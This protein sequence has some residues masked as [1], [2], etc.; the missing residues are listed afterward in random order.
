MSWFL[1]GYLLILSVVGFVVMGIDK[2]KAKAGRFRIP[3]RLL[4]YLAIA[5]GSVGICAGMYL[6]RHKT[7]HLTFKLGIPILIIVQAMLICWLA[8]NT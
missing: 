7:R 1:M 5:G 8:M 6:F 3:E 4:F 2:A